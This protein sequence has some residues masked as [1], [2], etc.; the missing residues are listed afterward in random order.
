MFELIK[1][2]FF[3]KQDVSLSMNLKER[4]SQ[5][6]SKNIFGGEESRS[7]EGSNMVQTAEIRRELPKLLRE[8]EIKTFMDAP[9]GDWHWMKELPLGVDQYIGVDIVDS[10]IESNR[11]QF[12]NAA[13]SFVCL[14]LASDQLPQADLIFCRDCL[15]HLTFE[16][17]RRVIA[18][19]KQSNSKYLLTT[20][21]TDR[22]NNI[23]LLGGAVWRPLNLE[24]APFNFPK[25]VKLLNEKCT[26]A[27]GQFADK[28][29][30]LWLLDE[31]K[32]S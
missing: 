4:F 19:F 32:L 14:N 10:L 15:V 30:G 31:I 27:N 11:Q 16:D 25:P 1:K 24:L 18:N 23:E 9:C 3:P 12:G 26:E 22:Q 5:I 7:G 21:F 6:Y 20:T 29:L 28:C 2:R 8:F 13:T 17:I